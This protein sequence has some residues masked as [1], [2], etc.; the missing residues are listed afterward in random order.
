[1]AAGATSVPHAESLC[2]FA[3]ASIPP[4]HVES[5]L[6]KKKIAEL[7]PNKALSQRE[8]RFHA[9]KNCSGAVRVEHLV[10]C[11]VVTSAV[12]AL[13]LTHSLPGHHAP[14]LDGERGEE[15]KLVGCDVCFL[16]WLV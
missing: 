5:R 7:G 13:Y 1:M 3:I 10:L 15:K 12:V 2:S 14:V 6:K 16:V 11:A 8:Q 4:S 9:M